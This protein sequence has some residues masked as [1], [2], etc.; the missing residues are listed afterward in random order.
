[1][2]NYNLNQIIIKDNNNFFDAVPTTI[3]FIIC[4]IYAIFFATHKVNL[5]GLSIAS[6]FA[7]YYYIH[8]YEKS[9]GKR[10]IELNDDKI[11]FMQENFVIE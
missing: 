5:T 4:F 3:F 7:Y 1:M 2:K 10:K 11:K 9:R 8:P 6:F